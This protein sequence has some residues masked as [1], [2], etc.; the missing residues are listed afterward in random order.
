MGSVSPPAKAASDVRRIGIVGI[1]L[2][3]G[4]LGLALRHRLPAVQLVGVDRGEARE[5]AAL[6]GAFDRVDGD[7]EALRGAEIVVLA[8]PVRQN[9][10]ILGRLAAVL[11]DRVIITDTGSTKRSIL[12]AA[13]KLP[14]HLSFVGGHPLAGSARGGLEAARADLFE[15]RPWLLAAGVATRTPAD[16]ERVSELVRAVGADA[17]PVDGADHDRLV[18]FLSHLPQLTASALMHVVGSGVGR[19]A[20]SLAGPGLIDTTRLA[21]SSPLIWRDICATNADAIVPALDALIEVLHRLRNDLGA[22]AAIDE[23]FGS[24]V[25]WREILESSAYNRQP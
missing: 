8:A 19:D 13:E 18:A 4:S 6:T 21:A 2:I 11:N 23:V 12:E 1:G 25:Q 9:V 10:A 5:K 17:R 24:A 3:G 16:V 22:G 7:L 20:L 14:P 15:G